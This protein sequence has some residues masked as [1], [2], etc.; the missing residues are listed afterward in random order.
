MSTPTTTEVLRRTGGKAIKGIAYDA[1]VIARR[2]EEL[3]TE[4][5]AAYPDGDLLV[6][7]LLKGSFIFL[8]DLVRHIQRPLQVD[9]L[10]ASSY[11]AE[12]ESALGPFPFFDFWGPKAGLPSSAW[13]PLGSS[14]TWRGAQRMAF[15]LCSVSRS[16]KGEVADA[17]FWF[18]AAA[19][20]LAPH[21]LA[22]SRSGAQMADLLR[23]IDTQEQDEVAEALEAAEQPEALRAFAATLGREE[24]QRSSIY[25][26]V[27]TVL[28]AYADPK[29]LHSARAAE[30]TPA[31]LL[32][33]G[34]NT[35][36][37]CGPPHEQERLAPL[38]AALLEE[39]IAVAYES[40]EALGRPLGQP[41]LLLGD[42][43]AN[44][45]P[46]RSLPTLASTG[47]GQGIQLVSIFQDLAQIEERWGRSWRTVAN[48][49]RAKLIGVG[50]GDPQTLDYV[51]RLSGESEF[52]QD[53]RTR[54]DYGHG[55]RTESVNWRSITPAHVVREGEPGSALLLYGHLPPA[56][57]RLRPYF[58][59]RG[60]LSLAGGKPPPGRLQRLAGGAGSDS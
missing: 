12:M 45:A 57:L 7:G 24:R 40:S 59:D 52:G 60:L 28:D 21:L 14:G 35:L 22:A 15:W 56:K 1:G 25:T 47:A 49:H 31:K 5:T 32:D 18:K 43:L 53:S 2:V 27:E 11:G 42:E 20:L 41:L 55:S 37:L 38:F 23:W 8:G 29:V 26:T 10:V 58:A 51:R 50:S 4:I 16:R 54:S 17:D 33:G 44:I 36:Y 39:L 46:I 6:L 3:G 9:F 13:S 19:K 48:S 30:I 34:A